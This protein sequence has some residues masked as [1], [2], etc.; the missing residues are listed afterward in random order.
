MYTFDE[1]HGDQYYREMDVELSRWGDAA[2]PNNAQYGI[3][4]FYVPGNVYQF[5]APAGPLT[6]TMRWKSGSVAFTTARSSRN[7]T[8]GAVVAEHE[9]TEG[10]PAPG[11]EKVK[12]QVYLVPSDKY[13]LQEG[14][15]VIIDKFEYL[16]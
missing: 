1:W 11:Q 7:G 4:P 2:N 15:E 14:G 5:K 16:P 3:Q 6:Y 8:A 9:F 13:P 12:L 10:V